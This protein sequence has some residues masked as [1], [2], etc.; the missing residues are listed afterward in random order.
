MGQCVSEVALGLDLLWVQ[1]SVHSVRNQ[2]CGHSHIAVN[3]AKHA[4]D[5]HLC[6][7]KQ[8]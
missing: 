2:R 5:F 7:L 4:G 6:T 1:L 8:A 3:N